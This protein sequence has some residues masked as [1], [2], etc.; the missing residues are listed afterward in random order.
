MLTAPTSL[1]VVVAQRRRVSKKGIARAIGSLSNGLRPSRGVS[2]FQCDGHR[3]FIVSHRPAVRPIQTPRAA[4]PIFTQFR[5]ASPQRGGCVIVERD[6]PHG[7]CRIDGDRQTLN[8]LKEI[9]VCGGRMI[10]YDYWR[11]FAVLLMQRNNN[12]RFPCLNGSTLGLTAHDRLQDFTTVENSWS[13]LRQV[14]T[15][16]SSWGLEATPQMIPSLFAFTTGPAMG[17]DCLLGGVENP[18][19]A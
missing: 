11:A 7:V 12:R 8:D 3:T 10:G 13:F 19:V 9:Y 4:P 2:S 5:T 14:F 18:K 1:T 6:A 17:L 16:P 15:S